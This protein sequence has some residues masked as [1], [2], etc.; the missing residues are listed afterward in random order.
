[1]TGAS[2]YVAGDTV[3]FNYPPLEALRPFSLT[4]LLADPWSGQGFPWLVTYGTFDPIAHILR[5]ALGAPATLAVLCYL[6]FVMGTWLAALLFRGWG[7]SVMGAF[8]GAI[9]YAAAF[10]WT[11]DGDYPLALSLPLYPLAL[12][13]FEKGSTHPVRTAILFSLITAYGWL[14]G[15]F[16]YMPLILFATSVFVLR[17]ASVDIHRHWSTVLACGVGAMCGTLLASIKL[18]PALAYV[19]LS[20]RAGGL[21]VSAGT[22]GA[23]GLSSL[24]SSLFPFLRI[25]LI[26]G[27]GNIA[28]GSMGIVLLCCGLLL[29]RNWSKW[30]TLAIALVVIIALP[31]SPLFVVLQHIPFF[32]F[33]R[34]ATR[35]LFL[36]YLPAG[37][38]AARAAETFAD[39][40]G[41]N[42]RAAVGWVMVVVSSVI[43]LLSLTVTILHAFFTERVLA[44]GVAYFDAHLLQYTSGLPLDHYHRVIERTWETLS[45]SVSLASPLFLLPLA[46]LFAAAYVLLSPRISQRT[47]GWQISLFLLLTLCTAIPPLAFNHPRAPASIID[48]V[49]TSFVK[50]SL[51]A[52]NVLPVMPAFADYVERGSRVQDVPDEQLRYTL[53]LL[54]PNSQALT[55]VR[56]IDFYQPIQASRMARILAVLGSDTAPA[57]DSE[58]LVQLPLPLEDR[59][60]LFVDRVPL[61]RILNVEAV[62]SAWELPKPF[63]PLSELQPVPSLSPLHIYRLPSPRT[64]VYS[65]S[66]IDVV[67]PDEDRAMQWLRDLREDDRTLIE[68]SACDETTNPGAIGTVTTSNL[69]VSFDTNSDADQWVVISRPRIPGWRVSIDGVPVATAIANGMYFGVRVPTGHHHVECA[70]SYSSLFIDSMK[71][72]LTKRD[73]WLL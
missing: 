69:A 24:V 46:G 51:P 18:L 52:G 65:P 72:L 11:G 13:L 25:P 56:S 43:L 29:R 2:V 26:G 15:H 33:L 28:I 58:R 53:S 68:C 38:L 63:E 34:G 47:H 31:A 55:K 71:F 3:G 49:R 32:S 37:F 10:F 19:Q 45:A 5:V 21:S 42:V 9:I 39:G 22:R 64:L 23:L 6:S 62:V 66:S 57:P 16:N 59:L 54:T 1:M 60:Q 73:P 30:P 44:W 36:G 20:E 70:M 12:L 27:T 41:K 8:L 35:W 14:A 7:C 61:M 50:I 40:D 48:D 4:S 67:R 17:R